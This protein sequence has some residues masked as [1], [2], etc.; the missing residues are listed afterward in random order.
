MRFV[1]RGRERLEK[2]TKPDIDS[3]PHENSFHFLCGVAGAGY[4]YTL[5]IET[6]MSVKLLVEKR[7]WVNDSIAK[8]TFESQLQ[9]TGVHFW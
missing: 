9:H 7:F 2:H 6:R 1:N 8:V 3:E 5:Q 4:R